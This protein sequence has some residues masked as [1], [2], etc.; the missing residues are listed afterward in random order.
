MV[1]LEFS[2]YLKLD[3]K[4]M[5][6]ILSYYSYFCWGTLQLLYQSCG[7]QA[8]SALSGF[9]GMLLRNVSNVGDNV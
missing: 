6:G 7:A 3:I 2:G 9:A 5:T 4:I 8:R 1:V